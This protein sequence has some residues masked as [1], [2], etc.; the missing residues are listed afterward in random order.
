LKWKTSRLFKIY[1]SYQVYS[2]C[3]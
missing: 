3:N 2:R 1:F